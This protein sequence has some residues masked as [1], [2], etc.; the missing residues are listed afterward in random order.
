MLALCTYSLD[1]C[2]A[3]EVMDVIR[4]HEFA[5]VRKEGKWELVE[6]AVY[7]QAKQA[8]LPIDSSAY[9]PDYTSL[10]DGT[11]QRNQTGYLSFTNPLLPNWQLLSLSRLSS[12]AISDQS[13]A[14]GYCLLESLKESGFTFLGFPAHGL[15]LLSSV[16][17]GDYFP[18]SLVWQLCY[19]ITLRLSRVLCG[20]SKIMTPINGS[21]KM[22]PCA[23]PLGGDQ[24][25]GNSPRRLGH[26]YFQDAGLS[27]W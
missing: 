3:T 21:V 18:Q 12:E 11:E 2:G 20:S 25:A 5:L 13:L 27:T 15:S 6:N 19:R 22:S 7:K 23:C 24:K 17:V 26:E 9:R 14:S 4:N 1:K 8:L 16:I 10:S